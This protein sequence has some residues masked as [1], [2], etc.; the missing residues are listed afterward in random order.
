MITAKTVD[1]ISRRRAEI[2]TISAEASV[3]QAAVKMQESQVG[4]LLALSRTGKV[5]GIITERD[6]VNKVVATGDSP[7]VV[8]VEDVMN[9]S[10]I[11][12]APNT[13]ADEA[14]RLMAD[15]RIRHLPI[16]EH[17]VPIGM[18]SSRD[19]LA[20]QLSVM[21]AMV[22]H[23]AKILDQLEVEHPGITQLQRT[24]SGRLVI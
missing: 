10:V 3:A 18:I 23:Q 2:L 1:R 9:K 14:H 21:Q 12:C 20:H 17:G 19:L 22:Q 7:Q 4:C 5:C 24:S 13:P 6:I 8:R 15:H 16:I 11:S